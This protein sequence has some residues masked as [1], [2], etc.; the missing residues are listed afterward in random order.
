MALVAFG[1]AMRLSSSASCR[2]VKTPPFTGVHLFA[3][4]CHEVEDVRCAG[5]GLRSDR[6]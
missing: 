6:L 1:A 4:D 3:G 2:W 5:Y